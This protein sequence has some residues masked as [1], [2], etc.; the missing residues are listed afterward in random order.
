MKKKVNFLTGNLNEKGPLSKSLKEY[1]SKNID[2]FDPD[3]TSYIMQ[4]VKD[5]PERTREMITNLPEG[6]LENAPEVIQKN[7]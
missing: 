5:G 6:Y 1:Y 2:P 4:Y 3:L 7:I